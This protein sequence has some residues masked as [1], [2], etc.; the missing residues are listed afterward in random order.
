M[1]LGRP[2]LYKPEY[3][4]QVIDHMAKG[5]SFWS[6]AAEIDVCMDTL[7]EWC[8]VHPD[9]SEAKRVGQAKLLKFDEQL[10]LT[11]S[12]GQLSR[13]ARVER[14]TDP[15][16]GETREIKHYESATFS[17]SY[18]IFKMKN[19]YPKLYRDKIVIE[20]GSA[21]SERLGNKLKELM[22]DPE[23]RETAMKLARKL[24]S[25]DEPSSAE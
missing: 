17:Q 5:H 6:F 10:A 18:H 21:K 3:C 25:S 1:R 24:S 8:K 14:I 16:T 4:Q 23:M 22:K 13:V 9:F 12:S 7:S 20:E 19:R 15:I 11:G 2:T